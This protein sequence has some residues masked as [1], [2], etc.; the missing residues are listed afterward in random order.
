MR[1]E[2]TVPQLG[3]A[4]LSFLAE[5]TGA[6]AGAFFKGEAGRF[7]R[8]AMLGVPDSAG[9]PETFGVNEG[10]L[11]KVAADAEPTILSD[12]PD[13][14]LRIGSALGSNAPR[15]LVIAP[16]FNEG[17]VNAIVELGFFDTVDSRVLE[18]LDTVSGSV[19]TAL[20][21]ARF[22]ERLPGSAS[23][24]PSATRSS[25]RS[26]KR[27]VRSAAGLAVPVWASRYRA[28]SCACSAARSA[29]KAKREKAARSW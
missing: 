3:T 15:H 20:R 18:L 2:K 9:V 16:G 1:G 23:H 6:N 14:Y 8:I 7:N 24:R 28:S 26:G 27:T 22:R 21:S 11:G 5:W 13:G 17:S 4:V 10:L 12:I 25:M 19:G 29:S